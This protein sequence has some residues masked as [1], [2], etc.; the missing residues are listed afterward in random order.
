MTQIDF[1]ILSENSRRNINQ[2]VC[3]LCEKAIAQSMN[4]LL[5]TRSAYQAQELDDILW[6]FKAYSF[7][8]HQNLHNLIKTN[9]NYDFPVLIS[10]A[11]QPASQAA[12]ELYKQLLINLTAEAP[13][14][15]EKFKRLVEMVGKDSNEKEAARSRYRFYRQQGHTLDKFDL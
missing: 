9:V 12:P 14:F 10:S 4:V 11:E 7:I 5:Y 13:P 3:R 2:M 6:T 1:Y 8:P 15:Y